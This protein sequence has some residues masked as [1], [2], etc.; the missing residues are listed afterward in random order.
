MTLTSYKGENNLS[1]RE[2]TTA[3]GAVVKQTVTTK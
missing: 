1:A 3:M 2:T